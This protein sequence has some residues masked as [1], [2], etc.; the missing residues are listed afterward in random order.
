MNRRLRITL[1]AAATVS[2]L[3]AAACSKGARM[4]GTDLEPA[5]V[6][7][8]GVP[9]FVGHGTEE[10]HGE[11]DNVATPAEQHAAPVQGQTNEQLE[12]GASTP[13]DL[14]PDGGNV[15]VQPDTGG[16]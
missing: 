12:P 11:H 10:G 6:E 7:T 9:H 4:G 13:G 3:A 8:A 14:P 1:A 2:L 16:Q 5:A 15:A